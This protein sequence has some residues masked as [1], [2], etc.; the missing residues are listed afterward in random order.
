MVYVL[1]HR[2]YNSLVGV[3]KTEDAVEEYITGARDRFYYHTME[4]L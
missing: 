1:F 2:D 4:L 3:F